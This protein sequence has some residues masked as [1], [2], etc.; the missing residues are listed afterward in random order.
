MLTVLVIEDEEA[1]LEEV[2]DGL[3][4]EGFEVHTADNG[5]DGVRVARATPPDVI[6]CDINMPGLDGFAVFRELS[7]HEATQS[8]PFLFL[9]AR[10]NRDDMRHGMQLGA[11]DYLTKPF[12]MEELTTAI[13]TRLERHAEVKRKHRQDLVRL[14][15][16][17]DPTAESPAPPSEPTPAIRE[18]LTP[19]ELE[20]MALVADGLRTAEIAEE[21]VISTRTVETHRSNIMGKLDLRTQADLVR[22]AIQHG[23]VHL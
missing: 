3:G 12:T 18:L 19:R 15:A 10:A 23:V 2:A 21:L 5:L 6:V 14:L 1:L 13:H 7:Q 11:D 8:I 9:T 17:D 16:A 22:A 4:F 20:V